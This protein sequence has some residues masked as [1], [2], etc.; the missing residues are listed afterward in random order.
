MAAIAEEFAASTEEISA[1]EQEQL[2]STEVIAQSSKDLY[3]LAVN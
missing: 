1:S 3:I 2:T